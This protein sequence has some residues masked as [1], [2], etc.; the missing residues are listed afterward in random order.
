MASIH[1]QVEC[2]IIFFDSKSK[3]PVGYIH[4][5]TS[6]PTIFVVSGSVTK[7]SH[8]RASSR[9]RMKVRFDFV[10]CCSMLLVTYVSVLFSSGLC[11]SFYCTFTSFYM[12]KIILFDLISILGMMTTTMRNDDDSY[13]FNKNNTCQLVVCDHTFIS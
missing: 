1:F 7:S 2:I 8:G 3:Y 11:H 10:L 9:L 6:S 4:H 5:L 13:G 12:R